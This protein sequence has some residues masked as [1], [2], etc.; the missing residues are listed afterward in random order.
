MKQQGE[1]APIQQEQILVPARI[2]QIR[3]RGQ[4]RETQKEQ[5]QILPSRLMV[6]K[7][8]SPQEPKMT[9]SR[10]CHIQAKLS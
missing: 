3:I 1:R 8:R 5:A 9:H 2:R 10:S 7:N 4:Q 6:E